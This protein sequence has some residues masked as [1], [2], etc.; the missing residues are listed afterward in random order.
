[1]ADQ[2]FR[3]GADVTPFEEAMA[4]AEAA[5]NRSAAQIKAQF[6]QLNASFSTLRTTFGAVVAVFSG[7]EIAAKLNE[8]AERA[9]G[10][11]K[12]S[13]IFNLSTTALQGLEA[14][15]NRTGVSSETLQR[16]MAT[17]EMKMRTAGEQGGAAAE[18]FNALGITTEELRDP[19][20]SVQDAMERL[21]SASHSS[22]EILA[23][24]GV[25]AREL[26]PAMRELARN[27]N[28]AAE[29]AREVGALTEQE[30]A[31]LARY[32]G[33]VANVSTQ[34]QNFASRLMVE[35][36][37]ALGEMQQ[38][39]FN[40][41]TAGLKTGDLAATARSVAAE[42]LKWA[43]AAKDL[44]ADLSHIFTTVGVSLGNVAAVFAAAAHGHFAE[45]KAI[46]QQ[47]TADLAQ[48][49]KE[50]D[51]QIE[52]NHE[53]LKA[54]LLAIDQSMLQPVTVTARHKGGPE[55]PDLSDEFKK[56]EDFLELW[57][58]EYQ[59]I[60]THN[61]ESE[62]A[63]ST[64]LAQALNAVEKQK[65][66]VAE[67]TALG[68]V[69]VNEKALQEQLKDG[70]VSAAQ[71]LAQERALIAQRLAIQREYWQ[72]R[73]QGDKEIAKAEADALKQEQ[74][75]EN[76]A[77]QA[78]IKQWRGLADGISRELER[79]F[80][81]MLNHGKSFSESMRSVFASMGEAIIGTLVKI[82]VQFA[83]NAAISKATG[84]AAARSNVMANAAQAASGAMA[85]A[86]EI[87]IVGWL[88]APIAGA[89][90]YAAALA[91]PTAERG[92]DIPAGINPMV[93][94]HAREMVLP[95]PLADVIRGQARDGGGR[96]GRAMPNVSVSVT[97]P[98]A[99]SFRD[100]VH[101]PE[102]QAAL[103]SAIGRAWRR[104]APLL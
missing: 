36:A 41:L 30:I 18:K 71:F 85:S 67:I 70:E 15:A 4:R 10:M 5:A 64:K 46:W 17:L 21:G 20:F 61:Y 3:I 59:S 93:Q 81:N 98:D 22:A 54:A 76:V 8:M 51:D 100:F 65:Q 102:I 101:Q 58:S 95:A 2:Q 26:I 39:L 97:S 49:D 6:E 11:R 55:L 68:R 99:R 92:Y 72:D 74:E 14:M 87:P 89:A 13:E 53:A 45:A 83:I 31:V 24:V 44:Y 48:I 84:Q 23:A 63:A 66:D 25:R 40:V 57:A 103:A 104:G 60:T 7:G 19:A 80:G 69:A 16:S 32:H 86:A 75:A 50:H 34:W 12:S 96:G 42:F 47:G 91:F 90:V 52:A 29:A 73:T 28:A 1:M 33:Q 56:R 79:A 88:L 62:L 82:A 37:P 27:H 43:T 77:R 35:A 78:S 94:T 38:Q 9:E